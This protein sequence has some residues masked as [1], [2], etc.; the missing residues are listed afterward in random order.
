[1]R[2]GTRLRTIKADEYK[3]EI[4][5]QKNFA[6]IKGKEEAI[7]DFFEARV[8]ECLES[9]IIEK[10]INHKFLFPAQEDDA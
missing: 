5:I 9:K 2:C 8:N 7:M 10:I 3:D 1:M 4:L 6:G